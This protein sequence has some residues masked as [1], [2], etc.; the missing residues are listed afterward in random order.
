MKKTLQ[1]LF[2]L[3]AF[4]AAPMTMNAQVGEGKAV[5]G[6]LVHQFIPKAFTY[7]GKNYLYGRK[8]NR[9]DNTTA[10]TIYNDELEVVKSFT[11]P[12]GSFGCYF[13]DLDDNSTPEKAFEITQ[14]LF[15]ADEKYEAVMPL[16][17]ERGKTIGFRVV[18]EDGTE[19]QSITFDVTDPYLWDDDF[20]VMK[21]NGK[22]YML[23]EV[24]SKSESVT[25][26]IFYS[27]NR[28]TNE[29][30]AVKNIPGKFAGR[31]SLDGRRQ[32][33]MQRGVNI[34][35]QS[36]GTAKKVLVK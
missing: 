27:I 21:I 5:P 16:K 17:D 4:V 7:D 15:N 6:E 11:L 24:D 12:D 18:S 9:E 13:L 34:V 36:D 26:T 35:R 14:T 2:V 20:T 32:E 19:L 25:Y 29:I 23:F 3:A 33:K 31:F 30:K 8:S 22:F 10:M 28:Q 1:Q